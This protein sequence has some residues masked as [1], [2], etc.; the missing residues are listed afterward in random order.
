M[1]LSA[2]LTLRAKRGE[3]AAALA[4]IVGAAAIL[5]V[6]WRMPAGMA[7]Q[8]GPAMFPL[9]LGAGLLLTGI[10]LAVR[11]LRLTGEEADLVVEIG[12]KQVWIGLAALA[13]FALLFEPLGYPLS[14]V[15][16]MTV[17]LRAWSELKWPVVLLAALVAAAISWYFFVQL[18]GVHLPLGLLQQRS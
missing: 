12:H 5:A 9:G 8:P 17:L 7:G 6:S 2:R 4:M 15:L 11:A 1:S 16:F 13:G 18:L 14:T 10:G 3:F